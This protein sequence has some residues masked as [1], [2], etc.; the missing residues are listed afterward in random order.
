MSL[1]IGNH[2]YRALSTNTSVTAIAGS[3]IYPLYVPQ[4]TPSYPFVVFTN[5]GISSDGTKDGTNE[6]TVSVSVACLAKDYATAVALAN[7]CRYAIIED[8]G[9]DD[10]FRVKA[11]RLI[12]SSEDF[13]EGQ[14]VIYI[15]LT[16]E[17]KTQD[18]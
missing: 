16:F 14:E 4:G 15:T 6:D 9:T 13:V 17:F 3:R 2:I 11:V 1:L 10:G 12:S 18:Y 7:A 8:T 5:N